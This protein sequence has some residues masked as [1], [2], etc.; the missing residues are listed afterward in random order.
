MVGDL[1]PRQQTVGYFRQTGHTKLP[2]ENRG[3][4]DAQFGLEGSDDARACSFEFQMPGEM[5]SLATQVDMH[6]SPEEL[7]TIPIDI[8]PP[9]ASTV[10]LRKRNY[11]FTVSTT[12]REAGQAPRMVLGNSRVAPLIG[13]WQILLMVI[14][15]CHRGRLPVY[16]GIDPRL[17]SEQGQRVSATNNQVTLNYNASRFKRWGPENILNRINGL[18]LDIKIERKLSGAA[19]N[20]YEV[21]QAALSGPDGTVNDSPQQDV[22]YRL[23][24]ENWLSVLLP[25]L[26]RTASYQVAVLPILPEISV[27]P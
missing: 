19:D 7:A 9:H 18:L 25:R 2:I 26:A 10:W 24:V 22:V 3:N 5:A 21:V 16:P 23:T 8:T 14:P 17:Y 6:L 27:S 20:T 4:S 15:H 1:S 11:S 12:L 13:F